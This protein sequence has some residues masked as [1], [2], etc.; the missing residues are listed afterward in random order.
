[1]GKEPL[2]LQLID[3]DGMFNA[4]GLDSLTKAMR[5]SECGLSYAVVSIMGPQSSGTLFLSLIL[6]SKNLGKS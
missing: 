5:F 4:S 2:S 6:F 1:M 3:G